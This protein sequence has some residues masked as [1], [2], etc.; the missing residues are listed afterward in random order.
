MAEADILV[1]ANNQIAG[2]ADDYA[3]WVKDFITNLVNA[4]E[5]AA[6]S[7]GLAEEQMKIAMERINLLAHELRGQG[8]IFGYPLI[9]EFGKSFDNCT[10]ASARVTENL[11]E[12]VKAHIDGIIAV[13]KGSMKGDGGPLSKEMLESLEAAKKKYSVG[14]RKPLNATQQWGLEVSKPPDLPYQGPSGF[15]QSQWLRMIAGR[16]CLRRCQCGGGG[17]HA[18]APH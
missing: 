4:H 11:L 2:M 5:E 14:W 7:F 10:A 15:G 13:I 1:S 6:A 16:R 18:A 12:F 3:D 17:C 9:T 8:G